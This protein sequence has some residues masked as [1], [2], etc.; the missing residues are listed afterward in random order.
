MLS[1]QL[2]ALGRFRFMTKTAISEGNLSGPLKKISI[3]ELDRN[4][5]PNEAILAPLRRQLAQRDG[6][7][8]E[9][10]LAEIQANKIRE[11]KQNLNKQSKEPA[12][13]EN[14]HDAP[15]HLPVTA[16]PATPVPAPPK[17]PR[18]TRKSYAED[19]FQ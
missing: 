7:P 14:A 15:D 12:R 4:Q 1:N 2:Q 16:E 9:M 3:E 19:V 18:G 5:Y 11:T 10:L 17:Q 8:V 13:L 6:V